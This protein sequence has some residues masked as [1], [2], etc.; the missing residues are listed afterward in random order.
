MA[1]YPLKAELP[2]KQGR[3]GTALPLCNH[4]V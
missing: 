3:E 1:F 2:A 4:T